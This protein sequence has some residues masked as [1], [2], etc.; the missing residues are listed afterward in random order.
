M[1]NSWVPHGHDCTKYSW[2]SNTSPNHYPSPLLVWEEMGLSLL[3]ERSWNIDLLV[4]RSFIR[5][6]S[7]S[8]RAPR[9]NQVSMK[10]GYFLNFKLHSSE[11]HRN[12]LIL[13]GEC[14][15]DIIRIFAD[16]RAWINNYITHFPWVKLLTHAKPSLWLGHRWVIYFH[17]C[18]VS[19]FVCCKMKTRFT[20]IAI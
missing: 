7:C 18:D 15:M 2:Y 6:M 9:L 8:H 19:T 16:I 12:Y 1:E 17:I 20:S 14:K 5:Q 4:H 10:N 11:T 3:R 13:I